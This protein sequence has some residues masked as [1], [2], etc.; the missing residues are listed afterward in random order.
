MQVSE[1]Q[2]PAFLS[3]LRGQTIY[4]V[5]GL[6]SA[7]SSNSFWLLGPI[8]DV[9]FSPGL[10]VYTTS[11]SVLSSV[12]PGDHISLTAEVTEYRSYAQLNNLFATQLSSPKDIIVHSS[13]NVVSP[14]VIGVDRTPP[15]EEL[16]IHDTGEDGWLSV[17]NNISSI[18]HINA[19]LRPDTY[20]LDFWE[21]L[22][23]ALVL[24]PSPIALNFPTRFHEFWVRGNWTATGVNSRGGL[25]LTINPDG[26]PDANPEAIL[27]GQPLDR[28]RNPDVSIGT[29][30]SDIVGIVDYQHGFFNILPTT[31]P[32]VL[33]HPDDIPLTTNITSVATDPCEVRFGDYNIENLGPRSTHVHLV[34]EHISSCLYS[35]DVIFLQEVQDNSG[36]R[37]DG[38]VAANITLDNLARA[39]TRANGGHYSFTNV[40]PLDNQ[41]GGIPGGNIRPALLFNPKKIGLVPGSPHG[42]PLDATKPFRDSDGKLRLTFNPARIDPKNDAWFETRKPLVAH[43]RT[44][45]GASFF[46]INHHGKSKRGSSSSH[47]DARPPVNG[48]VEQRTAQ[49]QIIADFVSSILALDPDAS[50]ILAG[51]FNDYKQTRSLFTPLWGIM[52]DVDALAGIPLEERYTYVYDQNCQQLDHVFVSKAIA[53]RGVEIEHVHVNVWARSIRERASDHDPTAGRIKVC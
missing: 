18:D 25:S 28:S 50:I 1:V 16:S 51:D 38:T 15:T 42:G 26:V 27:V 23:G 29:K 30:L 10:R 45:S 8:S 35:P 21:S 6:V 22:E 11:V 31:A 33:S 24:I 47:G 53:D 3:P 40:D 7:K 49:V 14:I 43:W 48:G 12:K 41:D 37:D 17:P 20:G 9:R 2:G 44:P 5:Q 36:S 52:H 46:T 4:N 34:A 32:R 13:D 39:I 19:T